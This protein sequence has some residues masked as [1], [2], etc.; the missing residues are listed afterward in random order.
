M[1][2]KLGLSQ[3]YFDDGSFFAGADV[4][5]DSYKLKPGESENSLKYVTFD[6]HNKATACKDPLSYKPVL[7]TAV[8]SRAFFKDKDFNIDNLIIIKSD[9][10]SMSPYINDNDD[11]G[12]NTIDTEIKDGSIYA[13]CIDGE[14]L[15]KQIFREAGGALR[16]RSFNSD[17]PDR[18]FKKDD[19][20]SL[21]IIG[22]QVYR[23]G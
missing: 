11:V 23:A 17:Y 1:E 7:G 3:M 6:I 20:S 22:K 18:I 4:D 12:I 14:L 9:D 21:N 10:N 2:E 19:F 16:L 8:L 13:I 5:V 15:F